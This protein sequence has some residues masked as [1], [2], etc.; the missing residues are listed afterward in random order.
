M[1][2]PIFPEASSN[3][4]KTNKIFGSEPKG[5]EESR[6]RPPV[7]GYFVGGFLNRNERTTRWVVATIE[8]EGKR[9]A[10]IPSFRPAKTV[11]HIDVS[12]YNHEYIRG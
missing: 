3:N 1:K 5:R 10:T 12:R 8:V 11:G 2:N 9:S 7:G 6:R 4:Q